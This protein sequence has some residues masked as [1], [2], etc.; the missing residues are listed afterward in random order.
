MSVERL[1]VVPL[2]PKY[3]DMVCILEYK[4]GLQNTHS[5]DH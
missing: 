5:S 4:I 3:S 1:M 2:Y